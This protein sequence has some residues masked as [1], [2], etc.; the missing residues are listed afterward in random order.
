MDNIILLQLVMKSYSRHIGTFSSHNFNL[1]LKKSS[2]LESVRKTKNVRNLIFEN[3]PNWQ[4]LK[5]DNSVSVL[6]LLF[7]AHSAS[8]RLA[9]FYL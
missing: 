7:E 2:S 9:V 1:L 3:R 8:N 4:K 5:S 6:G